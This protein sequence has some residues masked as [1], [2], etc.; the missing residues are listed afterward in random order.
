MF[1]SKVQMFG[2]PQQLTSLS[3]VEVDL[4]DPAGVQQ[5]TAALRSKMPALEGPVILHELDRLTDNYAF[6]INGEFHLNDSDIR[7]KN[8]DRIVLILLATGG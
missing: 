1:K 4:S 3:D 5:L 2:L 6:V 8:G 7:I